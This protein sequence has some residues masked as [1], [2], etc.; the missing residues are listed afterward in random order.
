[1]SF[2]DDVREFHQRFGLGYDGP[3]RRLPDEIRDLRHTM[4]REEVDELGSAA[5]IA[6]EVDALIDLAYF[7]F[8]TLDL[9][10]V[11]VNEAWRRVHD[12]N[13]RKV[14][15]V[16]TTKRGSTFDVVKPEG[17]RAPD[18]RDLTDEHPDRVGPPSREEL[19]VRKLG[20]A[21]R[22]LTS[23]VRHLRSIGL[24]G[25]ADTLEVLADVIAEEAAYRIGG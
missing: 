23:A 19:E 20:L 12:A 13:M 3:P 7:I 22:E 5:T 11:D 14:R 16:E 25:V 9:H 21:W 8:G 15:A 4:H 17:W 1:M 6:D 2:Y 18:L 10:G 24:T